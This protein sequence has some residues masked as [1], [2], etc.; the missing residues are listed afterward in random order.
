MQHPIWSAVVVNNPP[1]NHRGEEREASVTLAQIRLIH[2][3]YIGCHKR[4]IAKY[5]WF[6]SEIRCVEYLPVAEADVV[7]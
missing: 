5:S 4:T 2:L 7:Y 6:P 1:H 3:A